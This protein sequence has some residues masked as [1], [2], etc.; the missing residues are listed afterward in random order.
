[1]ERKMYEVPSRQTW[2]FLYTVICCQCKAKERSAITYFQTL[3][4]KPM[5]LMI[6]SKVN[7]FYPIVWPNTLNFQVALEKD[8]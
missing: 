3:V 6:C 4:K 1:M 2:Q 7:N 5:V 8:N